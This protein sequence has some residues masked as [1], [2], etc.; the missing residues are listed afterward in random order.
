MHLV[1]QG[2]DGK[3]TGKK[4]GFQRTPA[5]ERIFSLNRIE[6][7]LLLTFYMLWLLFLPQKNLAF[8]KIAGP[9]PD[10]EVVKPSRHGGAHHMNIFHLML[11][12]GVHHRVHHLPRGRGF[13]GEEST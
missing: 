5:S 3:V 9:T 7:T 13:R 11:H 4:R 12:H 1:K 6:S 10:F 8:P 2:T